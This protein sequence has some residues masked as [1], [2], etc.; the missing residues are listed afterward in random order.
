MIPAK[1]RHKRSAAAHDEGG[2][3]QQHQQHVDADAAAPPLP[4]RHHRTLA[5]DLADEGA[6]KGAKQL[7]ITTS[8]IA[9]TAQPRKPRIGPEFQAVLPEPSAAA[10]AGPAVHPLSA[11][12]AARQQQQ[13]QE[14]GSEPM[15]V[16]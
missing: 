14:E 8:K 11:L 2:D 15:G 13:Q 1:L 9:G 7:R 12:R 3:E 16:E 4:A 6:E 10:P 5:D